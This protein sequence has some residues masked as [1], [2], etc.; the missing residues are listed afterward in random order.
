MSEG[1]LRLLGYFGDLMEDWIVC[2]PKISAKE[3]YKHA[4]RRHGMEM[5]QADVQVVV[6]V[7]KTACGGR[8][9]I[10]R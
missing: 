8:E 6:V 4:R 10:I 3:V 9:G 2:Q 1:S 7:F 5:R